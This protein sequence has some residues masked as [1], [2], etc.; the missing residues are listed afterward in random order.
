MAHSL[1]S[2]PKYEGAPYPQGWHKM[3]SKGTRTSTPWYLGVLSMRWRKPPDRWKTSMPLKK[4]SSRKPSMISNE[5]VSQHGGLTRSNL[6]KKPPQGTKKIGERLT[7]T[8]LARMANDAL[9]SG[10]NSWMGGRWP[11]T[12][13]TM[14]W[15]TSP[16]SLTSSPPKNTMTTM[17]TTLQGPYR[18]GSYPLWWEVGPPSLHSVKGSTNSPVT[19]GVLWLKSTTTEP[20]MNS[21]K[22]CPPKLISSNKRYKQ[23][24]WN[25]PSAKGDSKRH[26]QIDKS[27]TYNWVKWGPRTSKTELELTWYN[28]ITKPA[29]D[30]GVHSDR[31]S[32]VTGLGCQGHSVANMP[33]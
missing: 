24:E 18:G 8:C 20:W 14:H 1:A 16:L 25:E 11:G 30:V 5:R 10:S 29:M 12:P 9:P 28:R 31:E 15:G 13:K 26:G 2:Y 3:S 32:G 4:G 17:T 19:I 7:S 27:A 6:S 33:L 21:A 23:L 22:C